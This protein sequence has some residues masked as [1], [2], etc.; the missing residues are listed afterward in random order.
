[1]QILLGKLGYFHTF[2]RVSVS[3][4]SACWEGK[5]STGSLTLALFP[6]P[7]DRWK[8]HS[9]L[10]ADAGRGRLWP[11]SAVWDFLLTAAFLRFPFSPEKRGCRK[12]QGQIMSWSTQLLS[13]TR[14]FQIE[15]EKEVCFHQIPPYEM[16]CL[17]VT[18]EKK[19]TL[20]HFRWFWP[21]DVDCSID[22]FICGFITQYW[23]LQ[24]YWIQS[25]KTCLFFQI[26]ISINLQIVLYWVKL[27][28]TVRLYIYIPIYRNFYF[29]K[30]WPL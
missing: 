29:I 2:L 18:I 23:I 21:F 11:I 5:A 7:W 24:F 14:T 8:R 25:I 13:S 17:T 20:H 27:F 9:P 10:S 4:L 26:Y 22:N 30:L 19:L 1:M 12:S 15:L 28:F 3:L 6:W 16:W